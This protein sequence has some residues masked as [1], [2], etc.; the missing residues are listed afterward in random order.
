MKD[1]QVKDRL[2]MLGMGVLVGVGAVLVA[3]PTCGAERPVK[4]PAQASAVATSVVV[5]PPRP[6]TQL[7]KMQ[8]EALE[9]CLRIYRWYGT[10]E[11]VPL[12]NG[13]A[14]CR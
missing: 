2:L 6:E 10:V 9:Q 14:V 8:G 11:V 5:V 12:G 1:K 3:V 13:V 4:A 7:E